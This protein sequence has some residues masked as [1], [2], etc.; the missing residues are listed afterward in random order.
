MVIS[1]RNSFRECCLMKL[2]PYILFENILTFYH[3]KWPAQGTGTVPVVSA[4]FRSI[5]VMR[6]S[7]TMI[8][9]SETR[10]PSAQS[11]RALRT[12]LVKYTHVHF[13]TG[14]HHFSSCCKQIF[15]SCTHFCKRLTSTIECVRQW[16]ILDIGCYLYVVLRHNGSKTCSSIHTYTQIYPLKDTYGVEIGNC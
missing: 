4:H 10:T 11:V 9:C 14:V 16:N 5:L 6:V 3:W 1:K 8:G 15:F 2:L 7:C 12:H 13:R